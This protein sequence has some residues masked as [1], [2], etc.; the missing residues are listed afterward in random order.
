MIFL[1]YILDL[2][3]REHT[4]VNSLVMLVSKILIFKLILIGKFQTVPCALGFEVK[5]KKN[6]RRSFR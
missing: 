2:E 3:N 5:Y 1:L 4:F 6:L